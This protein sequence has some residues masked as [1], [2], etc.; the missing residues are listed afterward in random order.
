VHVCQDNFVA[1]TRE[2][3]ATVADTVF[4]DSIALA[5]NSAGNSN[6]EAIDVFKQDPEIFFVH[7]RVWYSFQSYCN[8]NLNGPWKI[9]APIK[10]VPLGIS[11][12][13]FTL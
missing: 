10:K 1:Y 6:Q 12:L 4:P 3:G 5:I 2:L 13:A 9:V 7:A 11:N 8:L